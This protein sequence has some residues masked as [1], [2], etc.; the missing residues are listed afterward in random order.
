MQKNL[1]ISDIAYATG[2]ATLSH[3][4]SSFKEMYGVSPTE[5]RSNNE[6]KEE[7]GLIKIN[8]AI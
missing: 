7:E 3:F 1:S 8:T 5:Y 6:G 2:F 4:S